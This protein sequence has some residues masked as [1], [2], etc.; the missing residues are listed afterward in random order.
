[1]TLRTNIFL[2]VSLVTIL[3]ISL[4][5]WVIT[6]YNEDRYLKEIDRELNSSLNAIIAEVD[7]RLTYEREVMERMA[8]APAMKNMLPALGDIAD[9]EQP[10]RFQLR[11]E[12]LNRF[13][14]NLQNTVPGLGVVRVLDVFG[15][16]ITKVFQ[17][18]ATMAIYDSINNVVYVEEELQ[19]PEFVDYL[20]GLPEGEISFSQ[21][22]QSRT[23]LPAGQDITMLNGIIPLA[24]DS[25]GVVGYLVVNTFG[26]YID[27][28]LGL[29]QRP[30]DGQ[31]MISELNPDD[32]KRNGMTL[33][34]D[35]LNTHFSDPQ[36][37]LPRLQE[38]DG[39]RFWERIQ[40]QPFGMYQTRD[41][42]TRAYFLEYHP[43]PNQLVS[44]LV[45][46]RV[47]TDQIAAPFD[48]MRRG[49][50]FF[51]G[52]ALIISLMLSNLGA[53]HIARPV[54]Q[55]ADNLKAYADRGERRPL[56]KGSTDEIEQVCESFN[57][58]ANRLE[59][60]REAR[61]KAEQMALQKAKLASIGEMA[62]GIGHEINNPL[63][64]I[65]SLAKLAERGLPPEDTE[66]REDL[67]SLRDEALR[68][69]EIVRGIMNFARQTPPA[70]ELFRVEPW[71][72]HIV[73]LAEDKALSA[74]VWLELARC[75]NCEVEADPSQLHQ[76]M[77]NLI[78][79]AIQASPRDGTVTVEGRCQSGFLTLTVTDQGPG[80]EPE[81]LDRIYDPFFTTNAGQGGTGLGLSISLGIVQ[82]H[83]GV[84]SIHNDPEG[85][86]T[87]ASV[88]IPLKK[89]KP[90]T[91]GLKNA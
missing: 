30:Y 78:N 31:L 69:T 15:N 63:N 58:M 3:P 88:S 48:N 77:D 29:A 25:G 22:P 9:G 35:R 2:L 23:D 42:E 45:T 71:L 43:Y 60:A 68:A 27:R 36:A 70:H 14:E 83:G 55:L 24:R 66:T 73:N 46:I 40:K 89:S 8:N 49:I 86:G 1:M 41:D 76:V 50:I 87:V 5:V 13:L 80:V 85:S 26:E 59:Q 17:G 34:S 52:L 81:I 38:I 65:L 33:Y 21:I 6:E 79:N 67:H 7:N 44:W 37:N 56:D 54:K 64:N 61:E 47:D 62:A 10:G 20:Q 53:R 51:A 12:A 82:Y 18:D 32:P 74:G 90:T 75:D 11:R 84:M 19:E 72:E 91:S 28:T 57:Y 4:L 39:G 16:T